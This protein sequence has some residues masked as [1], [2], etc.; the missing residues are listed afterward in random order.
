MLHGI[1]LAHKDLYDT[2]GIRTTAQSKVYEKRVPNIDST[3]IERFNGA[4][5]LMLG[6]LSMFEFA[7]GGPETSIFDYSRN[8]WN[9][10]YITG[11]SS[12]GSA[13]AVA[14][15]LCM[16]S[17]GSDTGGSVR[18]PAAACGIGGL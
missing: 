10:D 7:A 13:A 3:V 18:G 1:P 11:G 4:G 2:K 16:G 14:A 9:T 5:A 12:S 15:S 17:M 6:K 8:P